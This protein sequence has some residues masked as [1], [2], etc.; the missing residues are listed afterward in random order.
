[1][2]YCRRADNH[3]VIEAAAKW[4]GWKIDRYVYTDD[5]PIY[6]VVKQGTVMFALRE[7]VDWKAEP[8]MLRTNDWRNHLPDIHKWQ[9]DMLGGLRPSDWVNPE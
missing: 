8:T 7:A 3:E 2:V 6:D 9:S 4:A 1:M 5:M